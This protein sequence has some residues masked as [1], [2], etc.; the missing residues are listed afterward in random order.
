VVL[1]RLDAEL[2]RRGLARSREQARELIEAG[3]V[4]VRGSVMT[5]AATQIDPADPIVLIDAEQA[6][7]VSRGAHKLASALD[8]FALD[9]AG[10]H[11]LDAGASTGGFTQMLLERGVAKVIAVDVG[12]GQLAWPLRNDERV[13]VMERTNVRMLEP[14][15]LPYLPDLIVSDLSFISLGLVLPALVQ[16]SKPQTDLLL[17]V[18]PQFEVGR[19]HVG[20][21]V[22]RDPALRAS[23]VAGVIAAGVSQG[24][25]LRGVTASG[26][27][28]P[29]GN[30]EYF[31]WLVRGDND[32]D[33]RIHAE[34]VEA[35]I[36]RAIE[37]GP[38]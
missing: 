16:C 32:V 25:W 11:A 19:E 9:P 20:D 8:A 12:Y 15:A 24:L 21:G 37:E 4:S 29:S 18:K 38:Q 3:A 2:A 35:A 7:Y 27:P 26:L 17:M 1:R 6:R 22:I 33:L 31:V 36:A 10:R 34:D 23:A 28:G 5:K 13:V 30:V 14:T